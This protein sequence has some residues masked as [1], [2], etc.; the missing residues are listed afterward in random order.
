MFIET[1]TTT[2]LSE[3]SPERSLPAPRVC[4]GG[5]Q[6]SVYVIHSAQNVPQLVSREHPLAW[7]AKQLFL[8]SESS[9]SLCRGTVRQDYPTRPL[10]WVSPPVEKIEKCLKCLSFKLCYETMSLKLCFW[11][12]TKLVNSMHVYV[13]V[14]FWKLSSTPA[15]RIV[16][17]RSYA[18][19]IPGWTSAH[20]TRSERGSRFC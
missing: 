17:T 8:L 10:Q 7:E 1:L 9:G 6:R 18:S 12:S 5:L 16:P 15:A 14:R 4:S 20:R 13:F 19:P 3:L 2:V 11:S